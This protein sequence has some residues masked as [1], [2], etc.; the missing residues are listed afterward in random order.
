MV[1]EH[2]RS[3]PH[4][5]HQIRLRAIRGETRL[6]V[7]GRRTISA[8]R[9]RQLN[10]VGVA[11]QLRIEVWRSG[12]QAENLAKRRFWNRR[13]ALDAHRADERPYALGDEDADGHGHSRDG[14]DGSRR[15]RRLRP[16]IGLHPDGGKPATAIDALD[17]RHVRIEVGVRIGG[18]DPRP[19]PGPNLLNRK[20]RAA[21][22]VDGADAVLRTLAHR[23]RDQQFVAHLQARMRRLG[24]AV[25]LRAQHL[26]DPVARILEQIFVRRSLAFDRHQL[27]PC[28]LRQRIAGEDDAHVRP[29]R[30]GQRH[31]CHPIVVGEADLRR[32]PRLVVPAAA[33]CVDVF[34][35]ARGELV[36]LIRGTERKTEPPQKFFA[37]NRRL[38]D[39]VD[40]ADRRARSGIDGKHQGGPA[41]LPI[42]IDARSDAR[43]PIPALA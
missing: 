11:S 15:R 29:R 16:G 8:I 28:G 10:R 24:V 20:R 31:V 4:D 26:L 12:L 22:N 33:S 9:V 32:D 42:D 36:G 35:H 30:H 34:G 25:A 17:R 5:K 3:F 27:S 43:T 41:G 6:R 39:D 18:T 14:T 37:R 7:H 2:L 40:G 1:D 23:E 13:V 19:Q 21:R 38:A